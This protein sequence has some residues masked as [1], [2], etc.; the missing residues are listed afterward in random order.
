VLYLTEDDYKH[1]IQYVFKIAAD[2]K[3][4]I[5]ASQYNRETAEYHMINITNYTN[6]HLTATGSLLLMYYHNK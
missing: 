4:I 5:F 6:R 2:H 1:V 3:G